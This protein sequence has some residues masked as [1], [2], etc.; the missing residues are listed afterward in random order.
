MALQGSVRLFSDKEFGVELVH[1]KIEIWEKLYT[2]SQFQAI[3]QE[4]KSAHRTA[5]QP[6]TTG[7][8]AVCKSFT[9]APIRSTKSV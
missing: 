6:R 4:K 8:L 3:G 2:L 1:F 5:R 9:A 7:G